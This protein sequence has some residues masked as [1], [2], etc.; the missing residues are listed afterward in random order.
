MAK[1]NFYRIVDE[2]GP[3]GKW[4][5]K[6][7]TIIEDVPFTYG[8]LKADRPKAKRDG[9]SYRVYSKKTNDGMNYRVKTVITYNKNCPNE[10]VIYKRVGK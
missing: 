9:D 1:S 2:K 8:R 10:R 6:G 5:R 7:R 4:H 3:D